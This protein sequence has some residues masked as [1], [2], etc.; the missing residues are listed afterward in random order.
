MPAV[1]LLVV[2]DFVIHLLQVVL[3]RHNLVLDRTNRIL[4]AHNVFI[5]LLTNLSL[6]PHPILS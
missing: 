3:E 2:A 1:L 5:S 4:Q 6:V